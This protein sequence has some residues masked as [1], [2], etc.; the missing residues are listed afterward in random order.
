M[1]VVSSGKAIR[2]G[3][4]GVEFRRGDVEC[5]ASSVASRSRPASELALECPGRDDDEEL[6]LPDRAVANTGGGNSSP[7]C[8]SR[9]GVLL[10]RT[11]SGAENPCFSGDCWRGSCLLDDADE[12]ALGDLEYAGR[13]GGVA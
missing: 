5:I 7:N 4:V 12:T 11:R 13:L 10:L 9:G 2:R 8:C 3:V 6:A 1:G